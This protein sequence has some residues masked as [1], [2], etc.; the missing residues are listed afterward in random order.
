MLLCLLFSLA[1]GD[2]LGLTNIK[3][4]NHNGRGLAPCEPAV[5]ISPLNRDHIVVGAIPD[6]VYV[7]RD[8]GKNWSRHKLKSKYGV[9]GDPALVTDTRGHVYY[10]HLAN[11]PRSKAGKNGRLERIVCQKSTDGGKTW[12]GAGY[13]GYRTPR[14]QDKEW[15]DVDPRTNT[16]YVTW[17]EFDEYGSKDPQCHSRILFAKTSDGGET[18]SKDTVLSK[19]LGNCRDDDAT[20][21]GAVP[22]VGPD[23]TVYVAWS[24]R[25]V[26]YFNRSHD[27]GETWLPEEKAI[28]KQPGGWDFKIPGL[29]RCN[30]LPTLVCDRSGKAFNGSLYLSW[31][32]QRAGKHDTDVYLKISRDGG[33]TWLPTQ[34][35]NDDMSGVHQF[36]SWPAVDQVTGNL[37]VVFY[38]RRNYT[39]QR[40]D[41]FLAWSVDGGKTFTNQRISRQSFYPKAKTFFGDYSNIAARDGRIVPVWTRVDDAKTSVWAAIIEHGDLENKK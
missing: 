1:A 24:L 34:R 32:D 30:G 6:K 19:Q 14:D 20:A 27:S 4:S 23:G 36:L 13:V 15:A 37:Y 2:E 7:T 17:T 21:E 16:I 31:S 12:K 10:F 33:E 29:R 26:I 18:W 41:V 40:T 8:G 5:T 9:W 28:A 11:P 3:L 35:V 25:E 38:D 39:N 22:A